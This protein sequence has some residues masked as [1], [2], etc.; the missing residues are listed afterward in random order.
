M[1]TKKYNYF[2]NLKKL[3]LLASSLFIFFI[4]LWNIELDSS[5]ACSPSDCLCVVC[6]CGPFTGPSENCGCKQTPP[7]CVDDTECDKD[8]DPCT[9][10]ICDQITGTCLDPCKIEQISGDDVVIVGD[11]I[12]LT[13]QD[14][15][16]VSYKWIENSPKVDFI[17]ATNQ[18]SIKV[19]GIQVSGQPNDV[20][21]KCEAT[22][23]NG[24]ICVKE[25]SLTVYDVEIKV[26]HADHIGE[27]I[28][29]TSI[30]EGNV[31]LRL[32]TIPPGVTLPNN[33]VT[34]TGGVK[35]ANQL[36]RIVP[37]ANVIKNGETITARYRLKKIFEGKVYVFEG[38]PAN[39]EVE[40]DINIVRDES[41]VDGE[42]WGNTYFGDALLHARIRFASYY[43][44]KK[45]K[46]ALLKA[47]YDIKWGTN[48]RGRTDVPSGNMDPF[49]NGFKL[50]K[51]STQ[52]QRKSIAKANLT[53]LGIGWPA[54]LFGSASYWSSALA[55]RHEL[56]HANDYLD[57]YYTPKIKEAETYIE[58]FE[59]PVTTSNL[60]PDKMREF[61][62][63]N[64]AK[65]KLIEKIT[66]AYDD[67]EP[68]ADARAYADGK[69]GYQALADSIN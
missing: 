7:G 62:Y 12:T 16:S 38:E 3:I 64:F 54:L 36:E 26:L 48:S 31:V 60:D 68:G 40:I 2:F 18:Q 25:H 59:Y 4:G 42:D 56:F 39:A 67:Y 14:C 57:N 21:I 27:H 41:V 45:W 51:D 5:Q 29:A 19:K 33:S 22:D 50:S 6:F 49:P 66:E 20:V 24:N 61:V 44:D 9:V 32:E 65:P 43:K 17:G 46:F 23:Q 37:K 11:T 58:A 69:D 10:D 35:G 53:P 34:W 52:A 55:E 15:P 28:Y 63:E 47:G 30:G 13:I 1:L 8:G